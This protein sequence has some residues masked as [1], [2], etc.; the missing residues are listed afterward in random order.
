MVKNYFISLKMG[1]KVSVNKITVNKPVTLLQLPDEL[2]ENILRLTNSTAT[3]QTL[4]C[5]NKRFY[6]LA[7]SFKE[8]LL[9][10]SG[11]IRYVGVCNFSKKS[12][13]K[14]R[15]RSDLVR[16][17]NHDYC[18]V[19]NRDQLPTLEVSLQLEAS[20]NAFALIIGSITLEN[21]IGLEKQTI[22]IER[23]LLTALKNNIRVIFPI[24]KGEE[25]FIIRL[26]F[27]V[28]LDGAD[29]IEYLKSRPLQP[30]GTLVL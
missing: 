2:L 7:K 24:V 12:K 25:F 21:N 26:S 16:I 15:V 30:A 14:G 8:P 3:K 1:S 5:V 29:Y 6:H 13:W 9:N 10:T 28:L 11:L 4:A 18:I 19:L 27:R 23:T 22:K 20:L 17:G